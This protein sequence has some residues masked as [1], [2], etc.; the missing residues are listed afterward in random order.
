VLQLSSPPGIYLRLQEIQ[1][2]HLPSSRN[3]NQEDK[4]ETAETGLGNTAMST[5]FQGG[6]GSAL[7]SFF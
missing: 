1:R 2:P 6:E 4:T 3:S 7:K 5:S